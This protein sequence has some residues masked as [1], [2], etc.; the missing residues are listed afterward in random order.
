M[1]IPS[2]RGAQYGTPRQGVASPAISLRWTSHRLFPT[3]FPVNTVGGHE[4]WYVTL[5]DTS[6][7]PI[8]LIP[9]FLVYQERI[10]INF[11]GQ[12]VALRAA[13]GHGYR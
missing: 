1:N 12:T 8:V 4:C 13:V 3:S 7:L 6:S 2:P 10:K 11:R 5:S 9:Q